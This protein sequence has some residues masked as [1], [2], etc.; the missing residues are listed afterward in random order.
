MIKIIGGILAALAFAEAV[1]AQSVSVTNG[2][3]CAPKNIGGESTRLYFRQENGLAKNLSSNA[4]FPIVCPIVVPGQN[5]P[6]ETLIRVG[7]AS[8][9]GQN[10]ACAVEEYD[11]TFALVRSIGKSVFLPAQTTND[12]YWS[13]MTMSAPGNHLSLR[14]IL[15]PRGAIGLVAWY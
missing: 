8:N 1:S 5:P 9:V 12:I 14:C 3:V 10:F 2:Y 15:P 6:Y 4:T 7:N 11:H 13:G